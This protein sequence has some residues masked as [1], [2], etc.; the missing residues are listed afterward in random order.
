MM[1]PSYTPLKGREFDG[2]RILMG[3]EFWWEEFWGGDFEGQGV[4][5]CVS[6]ENQSR[7]IAPPSTRR[8]KAR[9]NLAHH[10]S[11]HSAAASSKRS[12]LDPSPL[13][14]CFR[15]PTHSSVLP[16]IQRVISNC[17]VT[18]TPSRGISSS[19]NASRA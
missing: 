8:T 3:R 17:R 14:T 7:A 6:V 1:Y 15:N 19:N 16:P 11:T 2:E 13:P 4:V 18:R 5:L 10:R 9:G 12:A